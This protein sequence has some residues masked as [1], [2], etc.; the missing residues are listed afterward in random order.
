[1]LQICYNGFAWQMRF[2]M[3]TVSAKVFQHH[4]K[5]DGTWNVKICVYHQNDRKYIETSHFVA[6]KQ[7]DAKFKVKDKFLSKII[8]GTL[9]NYRETISHLGH[10]LDFFSCEALAI[11]LKDKDKD[12]DFIEFAQMHI[13]QLIHENREP[14]SR[15]FRIVK[16]SL[17]DYFKRT[18]LSITE[19]NSNMLCDYEKFLKRE[20]EQVRVNQLKREVRTTEPGL[21]QSGLHNHMR[22]LRT[23]FNAASKVYN[24]E[25]LGIFRIKH[26]PFKKY[27]VGTPP[28]TK[29]RNNT[30]E[31]V[32]FIRDC[33]TKSGGRA[34]LAKD[35]YMLSFYLCGM[36]AVDFYQASTKY[37][38]NGRIDYNRSKTEGRRKDNAFISI[39]I[40][41]EAKL[42]IE[43]YLGNLQK[44]Y[45]TYG[46]LDTALSLGMI[47]L[48]KLTGIDDITF[49]W[50]RHTFANLARNACRMSKDDVALALN[51]IDEGHRTT[52]IYIAKDWKIVDEVQIKVIVLLRKLDMKKIKGLQKK[53]PFQMSP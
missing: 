38:R 27:K 12:I 35:L 28:L 49:Y 53:R 5:D 42:L 15:S 36:N 17:I 20:R 37:I 8:E 31:E 18:S 23:L 13:D 6:K 7:L 34:E 33:K 46:G 16:N 43:K 48:R 41:E 4:Q 1:M 3:A 11:Y 19:I 2:I 40:V 24:N 47:T 39:K 9:G 22:D 50:A 14:Y 51:H 44:R 32:Q 52:D 29:K 25:D 10:K 45:S 26:Y 30:I 21:S